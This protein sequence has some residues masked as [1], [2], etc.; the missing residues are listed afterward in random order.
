MQVSCLGERS[1]LGE[2]RWPMRGLLCGLCVLL[3]T[4]IAGAD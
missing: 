3:A 4:R 1:R 2:K